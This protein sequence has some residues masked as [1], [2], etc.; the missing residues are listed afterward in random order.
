MESVTLILKMK[1]PPVVGVR[2]I[3]PVDVFNVRPGGNAPHL[4]EQRFRVE[5]RRWQDRDILA[6]GD[7]HL[8]ARPAGDVCLVLQSHEHLGAGQ[9]I[10]RLS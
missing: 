3:S 1:L 2:V 4:I 8:V 10:G 7:V 6:H 5:F 9:A